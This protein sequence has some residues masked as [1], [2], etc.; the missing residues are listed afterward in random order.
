MKH[1]IELQQ[2]SWKKFTIRCQGELQILFKQTEVKRNTDCMILA[3]KYV[4]VFSLECIYVCCYVFIGRYLMLIYKCFLINVD[5]I[6]SYK[7]A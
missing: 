2:R 6:Y 5:M 3:Y 1:G 7:M 4:V